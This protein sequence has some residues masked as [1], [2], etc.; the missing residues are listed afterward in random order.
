VGFS[1]GA[2]VAIA[3]APLSTAVGAVI[4]DSAFAELGTILTQRLWR[5][6]CPPPLATLWTAL[7][8]RAA[9]YYCQCNVLLSDPIYW[10][11][12]VSPRPLLII[13][14][15]R[16]RDVPVSEAKR[17]YEHAGL[18]KELWIVDEAEHRCADQICREEYVPR[19]LE[20]LD[21]WL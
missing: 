17:L 10:V 15:G 2:A 14:G 9:S 7:I 12:R 13:H 8:L 16:D 6:G 21:A 20:F 11:G 19:I 3:T 5:R 4:A 18:P 1:M